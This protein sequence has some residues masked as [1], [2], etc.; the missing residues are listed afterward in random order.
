M[1]QGFERL[2]K[3]KGYGSVYAFWRASG[4]PKTAI[5]EFAAGQ[6][7]LRMETLVKIA[8]YLNLDL[9]VF[10]KELAK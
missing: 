2:L 3:R 8:S 1:G 7:N 6:A 4:L 9:D 5:Y 10:F